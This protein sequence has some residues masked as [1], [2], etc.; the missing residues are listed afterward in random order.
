MTFNFFYCTDT[1]IRTHKEIQWLQ[2]DFWK[3]AYL[4]RKQKPKCKPNKCQNIET[5]FPSFAI[6][7]LSRRLQ[8]MQYTYTTTDIAT[9]RTNDNNAQTSV[10][11]YCLKG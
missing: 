9:Y 2:Q 7:L 5:G 1:S 6:E 3:P 4:F 8:S 11:L 10:K